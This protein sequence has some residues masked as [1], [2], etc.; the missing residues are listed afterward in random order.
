MKFNARYLQDNQTPEWE[1][2]YI[3]Y[4]RLKTQLGVIRTQVR[5]QVDSENFGST[6]TNHI[7]RP[8]P[9]TQV[10]YE[11]YEDS[12][13]STPGNAISARIA[14][15]RVPGAAILTNSFLGLGGHEPASL[16]RWR[17]NNNERLPSFSLAT[18]CFPRVAGVAPNTQTKPPISPRTHR[19]PASAKRSSSPPPLYTI[20]PAIHAKFFDMLDAELCKVATFYTE[21]EKE[22]HERSKLLQKQLKEL[23]IHRQMFYESPADL[24]EQ[25]WSTRAC[26]S[27]RLALSS[28]FPTPEPEEHHQAGGM[29]VPF[30]EL[31]HGGVFSIWKFS[32]FD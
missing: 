8:A 30:S 24:K 1:T 20:L 4:R 6:V 21:K 10:R 5:Q 31:G 25:S 18:A 15:P 32:A 13:D 11:E 9:N 16:V 22:L 7:H 12:E 19:S 2:A 29:G 23:G 3:D 27:V 14:H 17:T 28:C 26:F